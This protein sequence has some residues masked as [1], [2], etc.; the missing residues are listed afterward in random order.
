MLALFLAAG[1]YGAGPPP[2]R[3]IVLPTDYRSQSFLR[4]KYA[5]EVL[6]YGVDFS[7]CIEG[8]MIAS[9]T[10]TASAGLTV[11]RIGQARGSVIFWLGGT[12]GPASSVLVEI[13]TA[14]GR[15][16]ATRINYLIIV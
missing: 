2:W 15:T 9:I 13:M 14:Q 4:T 6:D 8:D 1:V 7:T 5:D 12:A 10:V 11:S 3:T 16:I